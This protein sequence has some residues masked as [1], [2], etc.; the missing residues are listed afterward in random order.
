MNSHN[1]VSYKPLIWH[2]WAEN[3]QIHSSISSLSAILNKKG[4]LFKTL[5]SSNWLVI[6][7]ITWQE[8]GDFIIWQL[9]SIRKL[10]LRIRKLSEFVSKPCRTA[11]DIDESLR[12]LR[13]GF[14]KLSQVSCKLWESCDSFPVWYGFKS[15]LFAFIR[16]NILLD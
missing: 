11:C 1:C 7:R 12:M 6:L 8:G 15:L 16:S 13:I 4:K 10:S 2:I 5:L 14:C 3:V 9:A